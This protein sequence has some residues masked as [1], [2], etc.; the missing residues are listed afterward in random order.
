VQY[1]GSARFQKTRGN[2][3]R[4][5]HLATSLPKRIRVVDQRQIDRILGLPVGRKKKKPV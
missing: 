1:A 4:E 3:A 2:P 5:Y